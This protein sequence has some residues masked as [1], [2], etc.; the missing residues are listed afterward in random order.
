MTMKN[1][2]CTTNDQGR[3]LRVKISSVFNA[4]ADKVWALVK[5]S[6]TLLFVTRGL[7]GFSGAHHFPTE[8]RE[9]STENTCLLLFI[10]VPAW[11]HSI[12]FQEVSASK[13]VLST[14][15]GGGLVP[16]WN[17]LIHV[18]PDQSGTCTYTDD[19]EVQAGALTLLVWLY[20]HVFYRYRQFRWRTLLRRSTLNA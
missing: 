10:L 18:V 16:V 4:P 15:E 2:C 11:G 19:V 12:T 20:A 6:D 7:L 8:W 5:R 14:N 3:E 13:R 1:S 9:G 17:H